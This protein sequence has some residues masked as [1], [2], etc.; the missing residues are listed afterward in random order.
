MYFYS[1]LD[2]MLV[3]RRVTSSIKFA[4]T[5]LYTRVER[6]TVRVKFLAKCLARE[7]KTMSPARARIRTAG[8]GDERTNHEATAPSQ[9]ERNKIKNQ[10]SALPAGL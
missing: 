10:I 3:P 2:G 1:P 5:H 6:G 8:S 7:H 9:P 4:G